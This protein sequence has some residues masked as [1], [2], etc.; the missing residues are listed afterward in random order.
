MEPSV[1]DLNNIEAIWISLRKLIQEA[2]IAL[3]IDM[4]KLQ[5]KGFSRCR[6]DRS[7]EPEGFEQPL[8]LSDGFDSTSCYQASDERVQ[9]KAALILSKVA[10][11]ALV[12]PPLGGMLT[13]QLEVVC[14]VCLNAS[15][16]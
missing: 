2:L 5:K 16:C 9:S 4:G 14:K 7:I 1:I 8:P 15:R 6:F 11:R 3:G 13:Q 12:L 10:N